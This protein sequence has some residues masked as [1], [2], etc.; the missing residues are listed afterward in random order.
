MEELQSLL[1]TTFSCSQPI[2]RQGAEERLREI[3]YD[4]LAYYATMKQ[5]LLSR[6]T[7]EVK[8]SAV[9]HM[10]SIV[11]SGGNFSEAIKVL[12]EVVLEGGEVKDSI[13]D[14]L[15]YIM[16]TSNERCH[17]KRQ[18]S[19][20]IQQLPVS[21]QQIDLAGVL[22]NSLEHDFPVTSEL[23]ATLVQTLL[24]L[25]RS[26]DFVGHLSM[27]QTLQSC[28]ERLQILDPSMLK[29]I[30]KIPNLVDFLAWV[31]SNGSDIY[32]ETPKAIA[33]LKS[34]AISALNALLNHSSDSVK[35]VASMLLPNL[36]SSLAIVQGQLSAYEIDDQTEMKKLVSDSL[37]FLQSCLDQHIEP[38]FFKQNI[39]QIVDHVIGWLV[40][41]DNEIANFEESPQEFTSLANEVCERNDYFSHK[42]SAAALLS[43]VFIKLEGAAYYT[44]NKLCKLIEETLPTPEDIG[45]ELKLD[46]AL[47]TLC[48]VSSELVGKNGLL[49][50]ID[51][52][53]IQNLEELLGSPSDIVKS[54]ICLMMEKFGVNLMG[55]NPTHYDEMLE[56]LINQLDSQSKAVR[57]QAS[58]AVFLIISDADCMARIEHVLSDIGSLLISQVCKSKEKDTFEAL[59]DYILNYGDFVVG[60]C[61]RLIE[62]TVRRILAEGTKLNIIVAKCFNLLKAVCAYYCK[63]WSVSCT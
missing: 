61:A 11:K 20:I 8:K 25:M 15:V 50:M 30:A 47:M 23:T 2:N 63:D 1:V 59:K 55:S 53:L 29:D 48:A 34:A 40:L 39:V 56:F 45:K 10:K 14:L 62:V 36:A 35:P 12:T 58:S 16:T 51:T 22:L 7:L 43:S 49:S 4:T 19:S 57:L 9:C 32:Q 26:N 13:T 31:V 33:S 17:Y 37:Q 5:L 3:S 38:E 21:H 27:T 42:V 60:D 44:V 18:L 41:T 6:T 54:R 46:L 24:V 28:T 52:V